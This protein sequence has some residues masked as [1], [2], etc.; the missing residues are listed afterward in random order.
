MWVSGLFC[1]SLSG[2]VALRSATNVAWNR[3]IALVDLM[4]S[5][6]VDLLAYVSSTENM[7]HRKS[8]RLWSPST[9][10]STL[11]VMIFASAFNHSSQAMN[12][13]TKLL[14]AKADL[15]IT[16]IGMS[17]SVLLLNARAKV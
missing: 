11:S 3:L 14:K 16:C 6:S 5:N 17:P 8:D 13:T 1:E 7:S 4:T 15:Q 2:L 12:L 9:L 10:L